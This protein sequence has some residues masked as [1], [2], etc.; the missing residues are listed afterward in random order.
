MRESGGRGRLNTGPATAPARPADA[1]PSIHDHP[2]GL[3]PSPRAR[4]LALRA[5]LALTAALLVLGPAAFA[6]HTVAGRTSAGPVRQ[7]PLAIRGDLR[8]ALRPGVSLPLNLVLTNRYHFPL[9]IT[10]LTVRASVDRRHR[11]AGCSVRRDFAAR[12]LAFSAYPIGLPRGR[13]RR[14]TQLG[15][16]PL[17]R[18]RMRALA[19]TNQD[20]C[21]G[22]SLRL[23]YSASARA[24]KPRP[25]GRA[26][27]AGA[28]AARARDRAR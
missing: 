11:A 13:T 1:V 2:I 12:Q 19:R 3:R 23:S 5:L 27:A 6:L 28:S 7:R 17:P 9:Q 24:R 14:L 21:K 22:A 15:V 20:A 25:A 8:V 10:R 18:I 26:A 16:H 4:G